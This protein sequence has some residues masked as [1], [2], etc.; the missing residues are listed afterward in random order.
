LAG[1]L[2]LIERLGTDAHAAIVQAGEAVAATLMSGG[3]VWLAQTSH[4]LYTE[5]TNRAGGLVAAHILHDPVVVQSRDCV[6][7]GTPVGTHALAISIA[8]NVKLRG[9]TLIA[10]TGVG[11][12]RDGSTVLEHP[13]RKRLSDIADIVVDLGGPIGDGL[14]SNGDPG[15]PVLPHS[16]VTGMVAM[17]MV[18]A[19]ATSVMRSANASPRF[20]ECVMIEGARERNTVRLAEYIASDVGYE[21]LVD[22]ESTMPR[23]GSVRPDGRPLAG[24]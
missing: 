24:A 10:L 23:D 16:G 9:A 15:R 8:L 22:G 21:R 12:E 6:I 7:E 14:F 4:C 3:K 20:Y 17:W 11:F 1:V 19:E 5:A 13:A 2:P 18:F